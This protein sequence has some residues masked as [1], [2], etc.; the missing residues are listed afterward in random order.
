MNK[1]PILK[2]ENLSVSFGQENILDSISFDVFKKDVAVILGPNGAGKSTLFRTLLGLVPHQGTISWTTKKIGYLPP[3][4]SLARKNLPP[5]TVKDFFSLKSDSIQNSIEL[6]KKVGLDSSILHQQFATLSTGQFQR[7]M[8]AWVLISKPDVLLLDEP[9]AGIDVGGE[10]TIFSLLHRIWKEQELTILLITHDVSI[11][12]KHA[13]EVLC[14][15]KKLI[16][17]G[18]PEKS[19]TPEIL[20]KT[21]GTEVFVYEHR[22]PHT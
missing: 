5:L 8:I 6:L 2:V 22:H 12:W 18:P 15:N 14:L 1:T 11:I 16:C 20:E 13:T 19:I 10:D 17:Y 3:Q 7:M 4:E 9:T 21:Y